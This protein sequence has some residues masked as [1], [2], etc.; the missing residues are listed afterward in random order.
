MIKI[1]GIKNIIQAKGSFKPDNRLVEIISEGKNNNMQINKIPFFGRK[2]FF[3][4]ELSIKLVVFFYLFKYFY[5]F[6]FYVFFRWGLFFR[7]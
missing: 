7:R 6:F 1:K 5:N 3:N 4:L 2:N